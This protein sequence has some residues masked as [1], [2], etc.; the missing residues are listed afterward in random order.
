MVSI[1]IIHPTGA[2]DSDL[3]AKSAEFRHL[4]LINTEQHSEWWRGDVDLL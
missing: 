2:F 3:Y 1:E 4:R